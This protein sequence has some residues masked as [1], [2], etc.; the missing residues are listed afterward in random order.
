[1]AT[2]PSLADVLTQILSAIQTIL[3]EVATGIANNASTLA[4]VVVLGAIAFL[5]MRFGSR[6]FR[7][8]MGW[9]RGLA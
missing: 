9:F 1:M 8:V 3:Y 2:P 7:G 4:T 6:M 5:V